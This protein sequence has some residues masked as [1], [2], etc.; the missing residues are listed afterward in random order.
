MFRDRL[1][2]RCLLLRWWLRR[3]GS[4]LAA[5]LA[6]RLPLWLVKWCVVRVYAVATTGPYKRTDP[7]DLGYGEL[8]GRLETFERQRRRR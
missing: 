4:F 1:A 8:M 7:N 5:R 2:L 6:W 3:Q